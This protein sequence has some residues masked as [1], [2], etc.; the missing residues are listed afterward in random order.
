MYEQPNDSNSQ[1]QQEAYCG[2]P[3][4][5]NNKDQMNGPFNYHSQVNIF[6]IVK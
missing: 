6:V 3:Q 1:Q 2:A 5:G 4:E